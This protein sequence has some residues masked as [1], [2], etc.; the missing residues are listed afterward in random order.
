MEITLENGKVLSVTG[1]S[2]PRGK[3]YAENEV[4]CPKR[5]VTSSVRATNGEMVSV[6][7]DNPVPKAEIFEVM[8]K[9]N[10]VTCKLP[11]KIGDVLL[12]NVSEGVNLIATTNM[13]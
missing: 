11:V 6:K 9:I 7:T 8:N 13:E 4:V 1:N 3:M 12:E 5:V 2:C 10:A